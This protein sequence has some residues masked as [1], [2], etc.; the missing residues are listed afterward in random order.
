MTGW[1]EEWLQN[2]TSDDRAPEPKK[3]RRKPIFREHIRQRHIRLWV[4]DCVATPHKFL[5]HD[6]SAPGGKFSHLRERGRGIAPG[7]PDT[8]LSVAGLP[9]IWCELKAP[10]NRPDEDQ[11]RMGREL[12]ALGQSWFWATTVAGYMAGLVQAGVPLRSNAA[13]MAALHDAE[14]DATIARAALKRG[15]AP[16]ARRGAVLRNAPLDPAEVFDAWVE[17]RA[18]PQREVER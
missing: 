10:G 6:R 17:E 14:A 3:P 4:R 2:Y 9:T 13:A 16:K 7:T 8:Q 15:E 18:L 5:A 12:Q 1:T 11:L